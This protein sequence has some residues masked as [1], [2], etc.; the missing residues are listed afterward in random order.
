MQLN[1]LTER[2]AALHRLRYC[3]ATIVKA[4]IIDFFFFF[5]TTGTK[6]EHNKLR[7]T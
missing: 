3:F 7:D 1:E 2:S 4:E 5:V 6:E